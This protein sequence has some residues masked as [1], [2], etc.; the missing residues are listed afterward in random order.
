MVTSRECSKY[1]VY[2]GFYCWR[3][4]SSHERN[5]VSLPRLRAV[6]YRLESIMRKSEVLGAGHEVLMEI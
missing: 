3:M 4:L 6:N 1:N 2:I 5:V